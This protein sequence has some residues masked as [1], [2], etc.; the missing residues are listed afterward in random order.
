M[1]EHILNNLSIA[2]LSLDHRL[3][4]RFINQS[5]ESLLEISGKRA[6]NQH[7][8]EIIVKSDDLESILSEALQTGHKFTR[9]KVK[10]ELSERS[11]H[12]V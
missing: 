10:L 8:S 12:H 7:I 4:L 6:F 2:V 9:R 11:F 3:G 5:A 1:S